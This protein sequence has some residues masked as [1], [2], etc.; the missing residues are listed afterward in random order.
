MKLM[1]VRTVLGIQQEMGT[2][3][4]DATKGMQMP[5]VRD[6]QTRRLYDSVRAGPHRPFVSGS[7]EGA[8]GTDQSIIHVVYDAKQ[9]GWM[10]GWVS[11]WVRGCMCIWVSGVVVHD[12][13][14]DG[15]RGRDVAMPTPTPATRSFHCMS[16]NQPAKP[17]P[18]WLYIGTRDSHPLLRFPLPALRWRHAYRCTPPTSSRSTCPRVLPPSPALSPQQMPPPVAALP[19][20][21]G[22]PPPALHRPAWYQACHGD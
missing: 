17:T 14:A 15:G 5:R 12:D 18:V 19:S 11:E 2:T 20:G 6:E 8:A 16:G 9:V 22:R 10:G 7:G 3:V 13:V 21:L 4:S 1:L